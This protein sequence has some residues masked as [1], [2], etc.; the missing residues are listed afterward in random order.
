MTR[1]IPAPARRAA[2]TDPNTGLLTREGVLFLDALRSAL[3]GDAATVTPNAPVGS[4]D[5]VGFSGGAVAGLQPVAVAQAM[6]DALSPVAVF[7]S[8]PDLSPVSIPEVA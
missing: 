3:G 2:F 6:A 4:L 5:P 7:G 1:A 8:A